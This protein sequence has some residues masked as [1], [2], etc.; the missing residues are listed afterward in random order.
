MKKY[1]SIIVCLVILVTFFCSCGRNGGNEETKYVLSYSTTTAEPSVTQNYENS[2]QS[3]I[4]SSVFDAEK[5]VTN[6]GNQ[7]QETTTGTDS[8]DISQTQNVPVSA[9]STINIQTSETTEVES[10]GELV[11][12]DS[13]DNKFIQAVVKKYGADPDNLAAIY[14]DPAGDG[15][16][17]LEFNGSKDENGKV[18]RTDET[19]V[20]VYTINKNMEIK[21]ASMYEEKT[22]YSKSETVLI[23]FSTMKYIMP[24]YE[25]EL[26]G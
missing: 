1:I 11:F 17:V 12:S 16:T 19:L 13:A 24:E 23:L 9:E 25:D 21:Y 10:K 22:E 26:M 5:D 15:N 7:N 14:E 18:I 6:N 8:S 4:V 20:G 2:E 3:A